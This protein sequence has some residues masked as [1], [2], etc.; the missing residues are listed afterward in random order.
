MNFWNDLRNHIEQMENA[1][2][3]S[4]AGLPARVLATLKADPVVSIVLLVT[5]GLMA[6]L[7]RIV[8]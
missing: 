4:Y 3:K 5:G 8:L 6:L 1:I 2:E 7:L